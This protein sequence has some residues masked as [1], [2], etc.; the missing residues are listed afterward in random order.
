MGLCFTMQLQIII[1]ITCRIRTSID[2]FLFVP[3]DFSTFI[4][5]RTCIMCLMKR[6]YKNQSLHI[7]IFFFHI[8]IL[9]YENSPLQL[10]IWRRK[11]C[12]PFLLMIQNYI[13]TRV[14]FTCT[15]MNC[16]LSYKLLWDLTM[17]FYENLTFLTNI[18]FQIRYTIRYIAHV[19]TIDFICCLALMCFYDKF[20]FSCSMNITNVF[21]E[22]W[23]VLPKIKYVI[24]WFTVGNAM[25]WYALFWNCVG[26]FNIWWICKMLNRCQ[27]LMDKQDML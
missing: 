10:N 16:I 18:S 25:K 27:S 4:F 13:N 21:I 3:F 6:G 14:C 9:V 12:F 20:T 5:G 15:R 11:K 2:M 17:R 1:R 8:L 23:F 19:N 24:F 7:T 26:Y 22:F